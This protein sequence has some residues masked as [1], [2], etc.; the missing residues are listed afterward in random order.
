MKFETKVKITPILN[1][2]Y[3][4]M[5]VEYHEERLYKK[6]CTKRSLNIINDY[7]RGKVALINYVEKMN[8]PLS[9]ITKEELIEVFENALKKKK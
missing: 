9:E 2:F 3:E 1:H 4:V 8:K 5:D 7:K 6:G